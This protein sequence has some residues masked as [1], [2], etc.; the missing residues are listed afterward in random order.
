MHENPMITKEGLAL[1]DF[2]FGMFCAFCVLLLGLLTLQLIKF[3][4]TAREVK[5]MGRG[6]RLLDILEI[7]AKIVVAPLLLLFWPVILVG[8]LV[9]V[10]VLRKPAPEW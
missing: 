7:V 3:L 1:T 10:R 9:W 2:Q 5:R 6:D 8:L 4:R